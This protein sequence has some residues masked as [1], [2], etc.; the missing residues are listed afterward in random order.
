MINS[1]NEGT[2]ENGFAPR[3]WKVVDLFSGAGGMSYGFA[4]HPSFEVI[5]AA[6][7]EMAKPSSGEGSL[8]C[9]AT[10][11]ENIGVTPVACDLGLIDP[12]KLRE[13]MGIDRETDITVLCS[14]A[15]CTG[16]SRTN[17]EN[18]LKDD[19]RNALVPRSALF[20]KEFSPDIF[21]MENARELL[22]GNQ[23]HHFEDL[24]RRL[25]G[26]YRV[27]GSI[28]M[29]NQFGLPQKRERA[30]VIAVRKDSD[31]D[32]HSLK[33]LWSGHT[34][35]E[36]AT[37]VRSAISHLPPI[38]AGEK[39]PEYHMHRAPSMTKNVRKRME[40]IP[41]DG[42]SWTDL[43]DEPESW[44][45]L[46]K[47]MRRKIKNDNLGSFPDVYG[48][49][50]WDQPAPTIKRECSHIGN[51][52]YSHPEQ[53]RL[54]SPLEMALLQGF[55]EDYKLEAD[56]FSNNYRHIGDAVPPMISYQ[57]AWICDWMIS[58]VKPDMESIVLSNT[59]LQPED[60]VPVSD[61]QHAERNE[62]ARESQMK[63]SF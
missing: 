62:E 12:S 19:P 16:F 1:Q 24:R 6:D 34:V 25:K 3:D 44:E 8:E 60:L 43:S 36:E 11:K 31:L 50:A 10:Y 63:F 13:R 22:Q 23:T 41:R 38:E 27:R 51:G 15:P 39:H 28:H 47:S 61:N 18:H 52:R 54:C 33:D 59:S 4:T 29:L 2:S 37:H 48:R 58:G 32:L 57:I 53:T 35:R 14:C 21:L 30:L 17:P 26:D 7:A 40:Y 9:N 56:N 20:V 49:M 55:P 45:Y 42:G 46:T 5:G